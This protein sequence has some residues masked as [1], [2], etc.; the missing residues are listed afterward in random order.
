[1]ARADADLVIDA[2]PARLDR[3]LETGQPLVRVFY[4]FEQRGGPDLLDMVRRNC[5]PR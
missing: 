5:T 3:F 2:S 4:R 1:M